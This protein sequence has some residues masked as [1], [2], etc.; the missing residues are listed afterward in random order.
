[1]NCASVNSILSGSVTGPYTASKHAVVGLTK[2]VGKC[3]LFYGDHT[4]SL[5]GA[6]EARGKQIRVNSLSPGFI[7]TDM[8]AQGTL[9]DPEVMQLWNQ[10]ESRQGRKAFPN[11]IGS[12]TVLLA[13]VKMG[14]VN[15]HNLVCDL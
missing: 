11:E 6:L 10:F 3:I 8:V 9:H 14:L 4:K 5:Q 2:A 1:V 13:S 12:A 15:A 7:W